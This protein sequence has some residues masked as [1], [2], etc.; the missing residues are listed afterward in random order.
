MSKFNQSLHRGRVA[1]ACAVVALFSACGGS[2]EVNSAQ[3]PQEVPEPSV[4]SCSEDSDCASGQFCDRGLACVAF[5]GGKVRG[6]ACGEAGVVDLRTD[7][8]GAFYV[9][10]EGY[11]RS[12]LEDNECREG[13]ICLP[14]EYDGNM[15][16]VP[17]SDETGVEPPNSSQLPP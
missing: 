4:N 7:P 16:G 17:R 8:C 3:S 5:Q 1:L 11:C 15:C 2:D 13:Y 14:T 10:V 6:N 12:C 9:C